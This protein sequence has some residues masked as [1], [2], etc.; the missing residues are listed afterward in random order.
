MPSVEPTPPNTN[1]ASWPKLTEPLVNPEPSVPYF[2]ERK[3][4]LPF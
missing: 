3:S 4:I 2:A 1:L